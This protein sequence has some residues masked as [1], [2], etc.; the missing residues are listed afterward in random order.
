M[1]YMQRM[2]IGNILLVIEAILLF[3]ISVLFVFKMT[4]LNE[5]YIVKKLAKNNYYENLY[6]ET[7][8]TVSYIAT[9]SGIKVRLVENVFTLDDIK[10]DTNKF[11]SSFLQGKK[12]EINT[13]L[14]KENINRNIEEYEEDTTT[15]IDSTLKNE[16]V[17]KV[18]SAYKNEVSLLNSFSKESSSIYNLTKLVKTLLLIFVLD[19]AVLVFINF[20][21]FRK[22]EYHIVLFSTSIS[23]FITY[24]YIKLLNFKNLYIYN[25]NVS[26]VLR[27]VISRSSNFI[28]IFILLYLGAGIFIVKYKRKEK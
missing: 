19:L 21:I 15:T 1:R 3:L 18:V 5:K 13:E 10:S 14:L 12:V 7:K 27:N 6:Q 28:I 23:L 2:I 16:F 20:K 8:D 17:G 9:K 25:S 26:N 11:V 4:V 24:I 22:M